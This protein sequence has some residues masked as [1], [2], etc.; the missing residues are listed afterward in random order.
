[1]DRLAYE[2]IS[3]HHHAIL[4][5]I[6]VLTSLD[7]TNALADVLAGKFNQFNTELVDVN[8]FVKEKNNQ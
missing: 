6:T 2:A 5:G 8:N 7:T 4:L 3:M 1:M